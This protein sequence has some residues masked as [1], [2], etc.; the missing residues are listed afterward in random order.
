M[1]IMGTHFLQV[2]NVPYV[3]LDLQVSEEIRGRD[4][5]R[6]LEL[7][8]QHKVAIYVQ[9]RSVLDALSVPFCEDLVI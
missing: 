6:A 9:G 3:T 7:L 8:K 4:I 1:C 5:I 2:N